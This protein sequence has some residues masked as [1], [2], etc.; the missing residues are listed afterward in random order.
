[1]G[2]KNLETK[3]GSERNTVVKIDALTLKPSPCIHIPLFIDNPPS[4]ATSPSDR[5]V[6]SAPKSSSS[7]LSIMAWCGL[8]VISTRCPKPRATLAF[9]EEFPNSDHVAM[10]FKNKIIQ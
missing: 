6:V 3:V 5:S 10:Y 7:V 2:D 4:S 9:G 1:M 8:R